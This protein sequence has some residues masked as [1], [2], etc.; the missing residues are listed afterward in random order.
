MTA[1]GACDT[2]RCHSAIIA[3][4][5]TAFGHSLEPVPFACSFMSRFNALG[6]VEIVRS[7]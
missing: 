3:R 2:R 6:T 4:T 7:A 5:G 1:D